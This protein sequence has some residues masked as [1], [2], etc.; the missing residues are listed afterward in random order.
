MPGTQRNIEAKYR[1]SDLDV[2]RD[3]AEAL[4]A[5]RAGVLHQRDT[6][7]V[8]AHARLKLRDFGDGRAELISYRRED[9]ARARGSDYVVCAVPDPAAIEHLL[10]HAL[11][12]VGEVIKRRELYLVESTRIHLD[13]VEGLGRFVELEYVAREGEDLAEAARS[14]RR[15]MEKLEIAEEDLESRAYVDLLGA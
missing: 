7:F 13:E 14:V 10:A 6:F 12:R 2:V 1:C 9:A 11:E 8:A 15:L 4:G 5:R 3:R